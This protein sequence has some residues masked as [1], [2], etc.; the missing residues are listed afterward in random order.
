MFSC[1]IHRHTI[2]KLGRQTM[3]CFITEHYDNT[4]SDYRFWQPLCFSPRIKRAQKT[5]ASWKASLAMAR[6]KNLLST[7]VITG[8]Y[9]IL[10]T[11]DATR[12]WIYVI[13]RKSNWPSRLMEFMQTN[14]RQFTKRMRGYAVWWIGWIEWNIWGSIP[15]H[16]HTY[17]YTY[18]HTHTHAYTHTY[19]YTYILL[20]RLF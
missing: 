5:L 17:T 9:L 13:Y 4:V 6:D 1:Y 10:T 7:Y 15:V 14:I 3:F 16:T 12:D 2:T 18:A 19:T 11:L 8:T 20:I